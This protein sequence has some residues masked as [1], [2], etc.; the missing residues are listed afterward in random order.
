MAM[1]RP[2]LRI[3]SSVTM[4]DHALAGGIDTESIQ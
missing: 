1:E 3:F 4:E 2:S